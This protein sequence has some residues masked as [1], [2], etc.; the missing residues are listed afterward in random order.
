MPIT[1]V[2]QD[3]F[4]N[5]EA[6]MLEAVRTD[7]SGIDLRRGT[8]TRDLMIRPAATLHA[9]TSSNADAAAGYG[10]LEKMRQAGGTVDVDA[11]NAILSNFNTTYRDGEYASGYIRLVFSNNGTR[12]L[13]A[14]FGFNTSTDPVL[15][16]N[17]PEAL[18]F[19]TSSGASIQYEPMTISGATVYTVAVRV[20]A[21]LKGSAYNI[22]NGTYFEP[23]NQ[24]IGLVDSLA[25]SSFSGGDD[26]ETI[27]EVIARLPTAIASRS[28]S[29]ATSVKARLSDQFGAVVKEVSLQGMGADTQDRGK[30]LGIAVGGYVDGYIRC[31]DGP[32]VTVIPKTGVWDGD[33]AYTVTLTQ[34][35]SAG[36]YAVRAISD[37]NSS[38]SPI[39]SV[40]SSYAF[41]TVRTVGPT[42]SGHRVLTADQAA[43][44]SF[45]QL[46]ITVY[47]ANANAN[48]DLKVE[49]F[50]APGLLDM[51]EYVDLPAVRNTGVD[52]VLK[53]PPVCRVSLNATVYVP[54]NVTETTAEIRTRVVDYINTQSFTST[55]SLARIIQYI[56]YQVDVAPTKITLS[57]VLEGAGG[58]A[59]LISGCS[60]LDLTPSFD[61]ADYLTTDTVVFAA[62]PSDI[63]IN[64]VT[65]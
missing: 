12:L 29:N 55:L 48:K 63:T 45:Q 44:S 28:L 50:V 39:D 41:S 2:T 23:V 38:Y 30:L 3:A 31:F 4:D 5:A 22:P 35:E 54:A 11:V 16:F 53:A 8:A 42:L 61:A 6:L 43:F 36:V 18:S 10:S 32:A 9:Y 24:V 47:N 27:D 65:I 26:A 49:L 21:E 34:A 58:Q 57:G 14:G 37:W 62:D 60:D 56:G 40:S 52:L 59:K 25:M 19:S 1:S 20:V 51:Q 17:I 33:V 46:T 15:R 7:Y 13:P 64:R